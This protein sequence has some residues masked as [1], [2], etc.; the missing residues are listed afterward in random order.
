MDSA[1]STK[2]FS[3]IS[4]MLAPKT[5]HLKE[6]K[7]KLPQPCQ[8]RTKCIFANAQKKKN[9]PALIQHYADVDSFGPGRLIQKTCVEHVDC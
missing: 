6:A 3:H 7:G 4:T 2:S 8:L 9:A 1:G 5:G